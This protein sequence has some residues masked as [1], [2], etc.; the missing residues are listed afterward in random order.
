MRDPHLAVVLLGVAASL[1]ASIS[2]RPCWLACLAFLAMMVGARFP[3]VE[4]N[5]NAQ[6]LVAAWIIIIVTAAFCWL[7]RQARHIVA[8]AGLASTCGCAAGALAAPDYTL[9]GWF[10][11]AVTIS[12]VIAIILAW[13][14]WILPMRIAAGWLVAISALNATLTVL[15]VTPGYLPRPS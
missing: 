2:P 11:L 15:P 10:A 5:S 1:A 8:T 13:K 6:L 7:P 14:G 12:T 9:F 4:P 3:W